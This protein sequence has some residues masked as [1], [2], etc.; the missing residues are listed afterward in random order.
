[1]L[2]CMAGSG[3]GIA[4]KITHLLIAGLFLTTLAGCGG[5]GISRSGIPYVKPY[6]QRMTMTSVSL[7]P[8][9]RYVQINYK[10]RTEKLPNGT[11]LLEWRTGAL[12][13]LQPGQTY[14]WGLPIQPGTNKKTV[15]KHSTSCRNLNASLLLIDKDTP[16]EVWSKQEPTPSSIFLHCDM[17]FNGYSNVH[18]ISRDEIIFTAR[19]PQNP[20][21]Q[22]QI[23]AMGIDPV[24]SSLPYRMKLGGTP[25]LLMPLIQQK[26]NVTRSL[27]TTEKYYANELARGNLF[28][29]ITQTAA[30]AD[31]KKI[32]YISIRDSVDE[33]NKKSWAYDLFMYENGQVRQITDLKSHMYGIDISADGSTIAFGSDPSRTHSWDLYI[34][35]L[36]TMQL[37]K[38]DLAQRMDANPAFAPAAK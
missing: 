19:R 3:Y 38:M 35:D 15:S 24:L 17:G 36:T 25:E 23:K 14:D 33:K 21:L 30:S 5:V 2:V 16:F 7:S 31:G 29:E 26:L 22:Q 32:A 8:D 27:A 18:F 20:Q 12:S 9:G 10:D 1:M 6:G 11:A 4:M 34:L 13:K 37:Y 28:F